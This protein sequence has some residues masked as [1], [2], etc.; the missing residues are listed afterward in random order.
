[1]NIIYQEIGYSLLETNNKK[2]E[3]FNTIQ[4]TI[5]NFANNLNREKSN[6][7]NECE[8]LRQQIRIILSMINDP[9]GDKSLELICKGLVFNNQQQYEDGYREQ[10]LNKITAMSDEF[11][12]GSLSMEQ[13]YDYMMKISQNCH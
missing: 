6:I 10:I 1:M 2:S 12:L 7:E 8:W 5:K 9:R 3:I 11:K 4:D 13:Q